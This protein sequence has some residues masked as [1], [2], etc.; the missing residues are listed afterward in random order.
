MGHNTPFDIN[1]V[2]TLLH[3]IGE[4]S[5]PDFGLVNKVKRSVYNCYVLNPGSLRSC[6]ST[7]KSFTSSQIEVSKLEEEMG[8]EKRQTERQTE[9]SRTNLFVLATPEETYGT[10]LSIH[11]SDQDV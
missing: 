10:L 8:K 3:G 7:S 9:P 5:R 4:S 11:D 6:T 2:H 1:R